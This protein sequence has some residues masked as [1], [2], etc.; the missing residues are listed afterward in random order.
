MAFKRPSKDLARDPIPCL[1]DS[2]AFGGFRSSGLAVTLKY[3]Q[4]VQLA[5]LRRTLESSALSDAAR[6]RL[7]QMAYV[8]PLT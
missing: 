6:T 2:I 8:L 1:F 5:G 4:L 3:E 7:P